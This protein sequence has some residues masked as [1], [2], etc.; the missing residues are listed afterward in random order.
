MLKYL[1]TDN[2]PQQAQQWLLFGVSTN[3]EICDQS[4]IINFNDNRKD[5][6]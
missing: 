1:L 2:F 5:Y 4:Q 6:D 3:L